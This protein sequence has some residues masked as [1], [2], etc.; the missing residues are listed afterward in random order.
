MAVF[1]T[2][3]GDE[4]R[5]QKEVL[6]NESGKTGVYVDEKGKPMFS[7]KLA[8]DPQVHGSHRFR[9][10]RFTG[11]GSNI[12]VSI[13]AWIDDRYLQQSPK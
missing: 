10:A 6:L 9:D 12:A 3:L 11:N 1:E 8:R 7:S 5:P 4:F 2:F 13:H